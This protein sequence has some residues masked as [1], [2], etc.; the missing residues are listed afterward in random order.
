M[1]LTNNLDSFIHRVTFGSESHDIKIWYSLDVLLRWKNKYLLLDWKTG[2]EED[3]KGRV[4]LENTNTSILDTRMQLLVYSF[5][6]QQKMGIQPKDILAA[7]IYLGYKN[8]P[9]ALLRVSFSSP[10]PK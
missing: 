8:T 3:E 6:L 4:T 5:V 10:P 2:T 1:I 9:E 7:A